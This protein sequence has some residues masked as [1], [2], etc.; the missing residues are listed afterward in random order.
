MSAEKAY[1]GHPEFYKIIEK[2]KELHSEKNRQYATQDDPLANF[3]RTG[4]MIGKFLKPGILRPLASCLSLM[5]KQV[6]AVYEM[7][8]EAKANTTDSLEEKLS[9]IAV[10]AILAIVINRESSGVHE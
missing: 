4:T 2:L 8:G 6:D 7:V 1:H 10:Y 3:R 9:D 5:S